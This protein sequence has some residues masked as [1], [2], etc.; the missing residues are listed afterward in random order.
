MFFEMFQ[1]LVH[2]CLIFR[3]IG[4]V[5]AL[6]S[7]TEMAVKEKQLKNK[8]HWATSHGC[9]MTCGADSALVAYTRSFRLIY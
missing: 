9:D 7:D 2:F 1:V 4:R 3:V 5:S 6:T 8:Q